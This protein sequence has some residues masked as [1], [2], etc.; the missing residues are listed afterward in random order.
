M[1]DFP[2]S[3]HHNI[4]RDALP[5]QK[6]S[7]PPGSPFTRGEINKD[8]AYLIPIL[9]VILAQARIYTPFLL[10]IPAFAGMTFKN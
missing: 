6:K 4:W 1:I 8:F 9:V 5:I 2:V 3:K 10:W 7:F